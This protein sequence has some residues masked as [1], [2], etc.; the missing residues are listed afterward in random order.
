MCE[1]VSI[2]IHPKTLKNSHFYAII[3]SINLEFDEVYNEKNFYGYARGLFDCERA[4][5]LIVKIGFVG[6]NIV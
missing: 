5:G 2:A 4:G 3:S 6:K 1:C